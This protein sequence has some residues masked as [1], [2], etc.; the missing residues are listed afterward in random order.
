MSARRWTTEFAFT[1]TPLTVFEPGVAQRHI[2][3]RTIAEQPALANDVLVQPFAGTEP[4][5][6]AVLTSST[7][8]V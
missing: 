2:T 4:K 7:A 1:A 6:K 8:A 3:V 5:D